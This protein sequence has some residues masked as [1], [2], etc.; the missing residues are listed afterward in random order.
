MAGYSGKPLAAKL[1]IREGMTLSVVSPPRDYREL[2]GGLPAGAALAS[3]PPTNSDF[4]HLFVTSRKDLERELRRWRARIA[5]A[6]MI[7]VSWPK[8]AAR[9]PTDV[10]EDAVR[11]V[12]LPM[13]LVDV[14]VC[15]IDEIWSGL[16]LV[17][18]KANR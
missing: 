16:K 11:E 3:P 12:A 17:I 1:G 2:V 5:P 15:A 18:R 9:V 14:K 7:W 8:R 4:V 13:G 10:T 6:G